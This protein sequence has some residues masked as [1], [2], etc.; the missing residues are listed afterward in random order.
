MFME[1]IYLIAF[2][3]FFSFQYLRLPVCK[4]Q[5]LHLNHCPILVRMNLSKAQTVSVPTWKST[6]VNK[7][8]KTKKSMTRTMY[9]LN[10]LAWLPAMMVY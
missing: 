9:K 5:V 3:F 6:T 4:S 1:Y 7:K 10:P 8:K 2:R